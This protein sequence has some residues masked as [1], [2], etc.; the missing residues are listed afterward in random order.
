MQ[1]RAGAGPLTDS[2]DDREPIGAP[3]DNARSELVRA[4]AEGIAEF[5]PGASLVTNVLR[6]THPSEMDRDREAWE[7]AI[8]QRTNEHAEVLQRYEAMLS[9]EPEVLSG[10]P[11][12]L[13]R[14][15]AQA[16][17]DG[18]A[19]TFIELHE[20]VRRLP[21]ADESAV[22][23]AVQDLVVLGFLDER[24]GAS[25]VRA[26]QLFYEQFDSQVMGWGSQG[27]RQDAAIVAA[28]MLKHGSGHTPDIF[29][30][31]GWPLRRFNPA[32]AYLQ[33]AHREWPWRDRFHFD[34]PTYGLVLG[35]REKAGLRRFISTIERENQI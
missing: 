19:E 21:D 25:S 10:M 23:Q 30:L 5:V 13:V 34:H 17:P 32:L 31:V 8:S 7:Q 1:I 14:V 11:A 26:T 18:L 27:T 15:V 29:Q 4:V 16:C 6:V 9:P 28:S 22:N 12:A 2:S 20:I 35:A 3:K 33:N 24:I